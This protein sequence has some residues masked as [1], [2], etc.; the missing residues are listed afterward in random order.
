MITRSKCVVCNYEKIESFYKI[1]NFP[2]RL[3][4]D[5]KN[6]ACQLMEMDWA[7]C[8]NCGC[9]QLKKL[10]D[11]DI[12]YEKHHNSS[13]GKTWD[14]HHENFSDIIVKKISK[15]QR[16]L[17]IGGANLIL[18]N[19]ILN[20]TNL[21]K[22]YTV[23]DLACNE[24]TPENHYT[25]VFF[26][27]IKIDEYEPNQK[28]NCVVHSH[29]FE[30]FYEPVDSLIRIRSFIEDD[31]IMIMSIPNISNQVED[32]HLNSLHFEHTYFYNDYYLRAILQN[33]GFVIDEVFEFSRWN[34]FY[35]CKKSPTLKS[36]NFIYTGEGKS[37]FI[38]MIEEIANFS[39]LTSSS[40][41]EPIFSFGA[42]I[43]S[44]YL[45][46]FGLSEKISGVLDNDKNKIGNFLAGTNIPVYPVTHLAGI[47][48]PYVILKVAQFYDEISSQILSINPAAK[49]IR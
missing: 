15:D 23:V 10:V 44:Q 33:A 37:S 36:N 43:F 35:V 32:K 8:L 12:L 41:Q 19:K 9:V 47:E 28:F 26:E 2:V 7:E 45:C 27:N 14:L 40:I 29:T 16:I 39:K 38:K 42:H 11:L 4:I 3:G 17:E 18:M 5:E 22:S 6:N 30:H 34:N 48:S 49:L 24:Y 1:P 13:P 46:A 25:N 31:G 21:V 20:K